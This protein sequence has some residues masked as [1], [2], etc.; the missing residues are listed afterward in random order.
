MTISVETD[1]L[2]A[3]AGDSDW[4][5]GQAEDA[6]AEYDIDVTRI[7]LESDEGE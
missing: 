5:Q 2:L 4:L 7:P 6:L 3:L 1:F